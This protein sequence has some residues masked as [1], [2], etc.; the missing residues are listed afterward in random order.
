MTNDTPRRVARVLPKISRT[1]RDALHRMG[2]K[3]QGVVASLL[4]KTR[5]DGGEDPLR[6][7]VLLS[8][9][10]DDKK[11]QIC[12]DLATCDP[13]G[14]YPE[15]VEALLRLPTTL[16]SAGPGALETRL[17]HARQSLE[18]A[19]AGQEEL[20][21][22]LLQVA[23]ERLCNAPTPTVVGIQGPPGNGKTT[24]VRHG[25]ASAVDAP[26]FTVALGGMGDATH[27]L[28]TERSYQNSTYGRL[29]RIAMDAKCTNPVIFWDELDKVCSSSR[30]KEILDLLVHLTDPNGCDAVTD[31][32][33]GS[34]NL[35]GATM[36]FAFNDAEQVPSVLLNR[37]K[38]VRT[39]GYSNEE[40][41]QIVHSHVLPNIYRELRT[42]DARVDLADSFIAAA[43]KRC[44]GE[45]GVRSLREVL[46]SAVQ[47]SL[48]CCATMG[49]VRLGVPESC[50]RTVSTPDNTT[51]MI[52][53]LH[54]PDAEKML[55][56][57]APGADTA[58]PPV[59]MYT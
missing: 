22:V 2:S 37:M 19:C 14:N 42:T 4:R 11:L 27:L 24:L 53:Y 35:R 12:R 49:R 33:L 18:A 21:E 5:G 25:L 36:V 32:F 10:P 8:Q 57:L 29:A 30:G 50:C 48:T 52:V 23:S 51:D 38:V 6:V 13:D 20:K 56:V 9:L 17:E 16:R 28:G 40:K 44:S 47:R 7:R 43:V 59:S 54:G 31:K 3:L 58:R 1:E 39:K 26:F 45:D 55:Q 46:K 15:Y 41:R 34:I